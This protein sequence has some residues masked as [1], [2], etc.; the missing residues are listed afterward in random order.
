MT[1]VHLDF[2]TQ[3][4]LSVKDVGGW[5]Y[6]RHP[7]TRIIS[8]AIAIDDEPVQLVM[9][10][11]GFIGDGRGLLTKLAMFPDVIWN[12]HNAFFEQC[13]W[14]NIMARLLD[15]PEIPI[16]H[17][18][19]TAAKAASFSL[20][21]D[22]EGVG[23]ALDLPVKKSKEGHKVMMKL[24]RPRRATKDNEDQ[25]W[26]P[27]TAKEDY[28][29]LYSYNMTDV[30]TERHVDHALPPL[31]EREQRIWFLD[32][33][34]NF[35][36][37][38]LDTPA[39]HQTLE[40][41]EQSIKELTWEFRALTDDTVDSPSQV[42]KLRE[43]LEVEGV[44]LPNLQAATVDKALKDETIPEHVRRA[45]EIRRSLSK[46][47][48]SK[49]NAML[50][51]VDNSDGRLRDILL[52][53]AALTKRWGGR[54]VQPQNL[55]RGT[56]DSDVCLET[57][58]LG[59]YEWFKGCYP[60]VMAAY[61]SCIRGCFIPSPGH[62]LIVSDFSAIEARV[63][64]WLA[65]Q[66]STLD[67]FRANLDV[68]CH[69]ASATF[70][71]TVVK[72]DK[73]ERSVGKVQELALGYNGGIG[74]FGTMARAYSVD[75]RPA[76]SYL[77]PTATTGEQEKAR[78]AYENYLRRAEKAE[79]PDPL[80]RASGYAADIVK[81]RW[82]AANP[83]VVSFWAE[84]EAAAIGAVLSGEKRY[85]GGGDTGRPC[86][87]FG[88]YEDYLL[89]KL[90]SG[91]CLVY[92]HPRVSEGETPW[93]G[94]SFKLSY[95]T[96]DSTTYQYKRTFTYGGKLAENATQAVAR[97]LLADALLRVEDGGYPIVLHVHDEI[98]SEVPTG[99]GSVKEHE[100]L[101]ATAPDWAEGLP[102][103]AEGWR[104][105]RYKK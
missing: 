104:G 2:E 74:A 39:I 6:T 86:I 5:V 40:F 41:I 62:E 57:I 34:I 10:Y 87:V 36:G 102:L 53:C 78:L 15:L 88:M 55:P 65:G 76:Y 37:I 92:P 49:Y 31:N 32:Q 60:D 83:E 11:Y 29:I 75:L 21:R 12:A 91:N 79:D 44:E 69:S 64:P 89:M 17:W 63:L 77:W 94:K 90:P 97:E 47:S 73:Y 81:Q 101:L 43:W 84:L 58:M 80:D 42:K 45:L 23:A 20:P 98:V 14:Y 27:V 19:C 28:N 26:T 3:S 1:N 72:T 54:G 18:R 99:Y 103:K 35:R 13:V 25:F 16:E 8:A 50:D 33:K 52:Y 22:L 9:D 95:L 96:V 67:L 68:Y 46:I 51:R 70:G 56:V 100:Q 38:K 48:T 7:S 4:M 61:S 82:R 30:E 24:S 105:T 71:R 93:G 85:V 59:D 66:E